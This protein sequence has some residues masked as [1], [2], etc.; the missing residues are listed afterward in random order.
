MPHAHHAS[1]ESARV[2]ASLILVALVYLRGWLR[3]RRRDFDRVQAW[4][5]G[6]FIS[7]LFLTW[8]AIGSPLSA[9]DHESLTAHM[10]QHLL[11]MTLAPPLILLGTVKTLVDGL[12]HRLVQVMG[13]LFQSA[14]A[15]R[16]LRVLAHPV[17]CWL[18][19]ASTLVAWH[20][21]PVFALGLRTQMWHGIEQ[22]SF[23]AT[24]LLFWWPVV[25]PLSSNLKW[26]ESSILLY[27]FL[28]T[29]PCDILSGFLV[30]CD[31]VVYPVFLSSPQ[32]FGLSALQ[33]QQCAGALMWTCV[34]IVYLIAAA[35]VVAR[36][37]S[38]NRSEERSILQFE[39]ERSVVH[40][41]PQRMEAV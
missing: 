27:L 17:I 34:T 32:S 4:R 2:S 5:A 21:P 7:G 12:P 39:L 23:L 8:I 18:G 22:A 13:R 29:L 37:L 19:A 40:T 35:I 9:L 15:S 3:L 14:G 24:G 10:A 16:V 30:F 38:P 28:A 1:V 20:I 41:D 6:S 25:Q 31:R 33:D 36:L 26:L 11:L